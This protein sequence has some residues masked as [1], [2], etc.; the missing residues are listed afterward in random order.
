VIARFVAVLVWL[1]LGHLLAGGLYWTLLQVPESNA[2]MLAASVVVALALAAWLA[3]VETGG[4]LGWTGGLREVAKGT[5]R[6]VPWFVPALL[7]FVLIWW[8]GST[9]DG[10]YA[11]RAT[12]LDAWLLLRAGWTRTA[13]LH[14]AAAWVC[15]FVSYGVGLSLA[16]SLLARTS[17]EGAAAVVRGGW[18]RQGLAWRQLLIVAGVVLVGIRLPWGAAYWRP[19]GLPPTWLEPAFVAAKLTVL[20]LVANAAWAFLLRTVAG[21]APRIGAPQGAAP[22]APK[23]GPTT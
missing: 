1:A 6:R 7:V 4:L 22:G 11:A 9:A 21:G 17:R 2:L 5:I 19:K 23:P 16:L 13:G 14:R 20:Y 3:I 10:W 15:W 12:E 8:L 18:L